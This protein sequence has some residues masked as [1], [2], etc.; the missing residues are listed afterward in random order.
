[1]RYQKLPHNFI[2]N[3]NNS[4]LQRVN[5]AMDESGEFRKNGRV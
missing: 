2:L 4:T 1:M 3:K 5:V